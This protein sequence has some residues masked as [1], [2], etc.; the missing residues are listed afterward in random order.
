M[1]IHPYEPLYKSNQ[2]T[3]LPISNR[4]EALGNANQPRYQ[5]LNIEKSIS[6]L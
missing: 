6:A 2:R 3:P 5:S 1:P 4:P